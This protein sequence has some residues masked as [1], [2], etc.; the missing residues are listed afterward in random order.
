MQRRIMSVGS[1]GQYIRISAPPVSLRGKVPTNDQ[2]CSI[3]LEH[4]R[5]VQQ[6]SYIWLSGG[7]GSI[8][9]LGMYQDR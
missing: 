7:I 2:S 4:S 8:L 6:S 9:R 5:L 3:G 1:G